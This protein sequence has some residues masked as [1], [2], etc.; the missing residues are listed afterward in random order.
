MIVSLIGGTG[1]VGT[2]ICRDLLAQGHQPRLLVRAG[3]EHKIPSSLREQ[4]ADTQLITG[5]IHDQNALNQ[6][7]ENADAVIYL[8]GLLRE[9]PKQGI[10]FEEAQYQGV[11]RTVEAAQINGTKQF[12]LM[13][14]NGV[15]AQGTAY[16][17]TKYR[18]EQYVQQSGLAWTIFRPSVIFGDPQGKMEFCTQLVKELIEPAIPAPLFFP[19]LRPLQAGQFQLA[20]V[21]ISDVAQV[22]VE[23]LENP[24]AHQQ[25]FT[26][27]GTQVVSWKNIMQT[28]AQATGRKS[29]FAL[30]A[31]AVV[32]QTLAR[33]L[34]SYRWFPITKDQ[35][36]MLL[37]SNICDESTQDK[38]WDVFNIQAK[39]FELAN[40]SYLQNQ[41]SAH[42]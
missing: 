28:L 30:P 17:T 38:A 4:L 35:I 36:T 31:P 24:A 40:L 13:S 22:F 23:S 11:V 26:L 29:K 9:F 1:F 18:A 2:A 21:H 32:V 14:A 3:S 25:L 10:S 7:L 19:C 34:D 39:G 12:I 16:Q 8:V 6:C 33:L 41:E 27:C 42:E 20:P 5:D 15:K 37:E